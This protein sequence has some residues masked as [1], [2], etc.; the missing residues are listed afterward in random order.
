VAISSLGQIKRYTSFFLSNFFY[1]LLIGF[2]LAGMYHVVPGAYSIFIG[3]V[4]SCTITEAQ[5]MHIPVE[6]RVSGLINV[7]GPLQE[8]WYS[9]RFS[10]IYRKY[11]YY[12]LQD[13]GGSTAIYVYSGLD[14]EKFLKMF[15]DNPMVLPGILEEIPERERRKILIL[16]ADQQSEEVKK[17]A[18]FSAEYVKPG[19]KTLDQT[20]KMLEKFVVLLQNSSPMAHVG[21]RLNL[22]ILERRIDALLALALVLAVTAAGVAGAV[23]YNKK[24][25]KSGSG[26]AK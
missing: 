7:N 19:E 13:A 12:K 21:V 24:Y 9:R 18:E 1:L 8:S 3:K 6:A 2:G 26:K 14:P 16:Q 17:R 15:G 25:F 20:V 11:Y 10:D 23:L 22:N 5:A 4:E